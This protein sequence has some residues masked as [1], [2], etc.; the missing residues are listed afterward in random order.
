VTVSL[1][2]CVFGAG[3]IGRTI[4]TLLA[5]CGAVVSV[6]ARGR[7]LAALKEGG[8]RLI[9]DGEELRAS[10]RASDDPSA[11]GTQDYVIIA[12][13]A[14]SLPDVARRIGPLLGPETA[15]VTA[16]NGVPWWFSSDRRARSGQRLKAVDPD[17]T[18]SL[19]IASKRVIGCVLYI[20]ASADES[21]LVRHWSGRQLV[22]G[23]PDHQ[24]TP[25]LKLLGEWLRRAGLDC[26]KSRDDAEPWHG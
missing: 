15:V 12:A 23:E 5:R 25:R 16:M 22:I 7:T 8:A 18:I 21:G 2:F 1:K 11:L 17:G 19:S 4:V 13:K 9:I 20:A 6:V 14:P 3:A 26:R 10:V 24:L